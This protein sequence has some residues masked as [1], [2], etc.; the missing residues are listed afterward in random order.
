MM[1]LAAWLYGKIVG[2]RNALY[3][4]GV[5]ETLHLGARTISIGNITT[6]GTGK[7]PLVALVVEML[8]D[9]G[10]RVCILTR[11]YGRKNAKRRVL[12]SDGAKTLASVA[13]AGDEPVELARKLTG[14][15]IVVAD[16]DRVA[17]AEWARRKFA[18]TAFVLDDG[19]QHRRAKRNVDIA[20]IDATD[21]FGG[22]AM[23]PAGRLREPIENLRRA[24]VVILTRANLVAD[25]SNLRSEISRISP[26]SAIFTAKNEIDRVVVLKEFLDQSESAE[27]EDIARETPA[28]A[29]CGIGN[30]E[31]F[32]AQLR[33]DGSA[34]TATETF[35]DHFVYAGRDV[36]KLQQ[37]ARASGAKILLTTAKDAVKL[38]DMKFEIPCYF[39]EFRTIIDLASD[40]AARI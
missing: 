6:G 31:S 32:F 25:I 34:V 30:P 12:V 4:K 10:E 36:E 39:V 29:F 33:Q 2:A 22:G 15:A 40:F 8:A 21:P 14:K 27:R 17:A 1:S 13:D 19:F 28:L 5:L 11:G 20:C 23:V 38:A 9:R 37:R 35:P 24:D 16:A 7:T 26:E 18:V 3:D